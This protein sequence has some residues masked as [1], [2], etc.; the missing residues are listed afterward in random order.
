MLSCLLLGGTEGFPTGPQGYAFMLIDPPD[1][2][3]RLEEVG[4]EA[5]TGLHAVCQSEESAH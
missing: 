3:I 1:G 5:Y 2:A 4:E